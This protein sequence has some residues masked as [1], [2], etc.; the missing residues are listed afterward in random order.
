MSARK[1][2]LKSHR[3]LW[4]RLELRINPG[5]FHPDFV[6]SKTFPKTSEDFGRTAA[7][8]EQRRTAQ[9]RI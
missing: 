8:S 9:L 6:Q 7:V 2:E 3:R 5:A 1:A 4:S